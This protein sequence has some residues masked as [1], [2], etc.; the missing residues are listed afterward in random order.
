MKRFVKSILAVSTIVFLMGFLFSF[1]YAQYLDS[2]SFSLENP[3]I[4]IMEGGVSTSSS[5]QYISSSGQLENGQSSSTNFGSNAGFLYFP[6]ATTPVVATTA[7]N[8]AVLVSW[9]ASVGTLGNVTSYAVGVSTTSG[10]PYTYTNVGN[11]TSNNVTGLTNGTTYYFKI[12]S[13]VSGLI[14]SE[15]AEVSGVPVSSS[16]TT[17]TTTGGGGGG[18]ATVGTATG[19]TNTGGSGR[20]T[21]SGRAYPRSKVSILKDGTLVASTIAD[22]KADFSVS[23]NSLSDGNYNFS[24]YGYDTNDR[25]STSFSF[26]LYITEN[27]TINIGGIF[28]SP[29]IDIDKSSVKRGEN[30]AIFGQSVPE[31]DVTISVHSEQEFFN[32]VKTDKDG[33]Y[34]LNFDTTPLEIGGH[35]AKSKSAY[36]TEVSPFGN[37]VAFKVGTETKIKEAMTCSTLRG[38]LNCDKKVNLVDFS[39]M[40]YWYKKSSPPDNVDLNKDGKINLVDFSIM[41]FNWTG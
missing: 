2:S 35:S 11:V 9:T 4:G 39:I 20:V 37:T 38:D 21:F 23:I 40:A 10:G 12:R 8:A 18:G 15:S 7:S 13:Y 22:P 32:K 33:V 36:A 27:S 16:P 29:T 26:P 28:L 5:F 6:I 25:K 17:T 31:S 24:V 34:L 19:N 3:L 14:V 41:A 30:V 1:A